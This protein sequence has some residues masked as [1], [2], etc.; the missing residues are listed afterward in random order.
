MNYNSSFYEFDLRGVSN[1]FFHIFI[2]PCWK[3]ICESYA[4][5]FNPSAANNAIYVFSSLLC[6][7]RH[8]INLIYRMYFHG[9]SVMNSREEYYENASLHMKI[10]I[11]FYIIQLHLL[12]DHY[13]PKYGW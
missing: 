3:H 7:G 6:F 4:H 1:Y 10:E 5:I 9:I 12:D 13:L 11:L 2:K 8:L